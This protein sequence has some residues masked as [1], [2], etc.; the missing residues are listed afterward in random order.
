MARFG[1]RLFVATYFIRRQK[2]LTHGRQPNKG[3][4]TRSVFFH[5]SLDDR[6]LFAKRLAILL[7]AG[8]PILEGLRMLQKQIRGRSAQYVLMEIA[9]GIEEGLSLHSCLEKFHNFFGDFFINVVR[10]GESTGTLHQSLEYL[11]EELRKQR[12]MKKKII[13]ALVY[14]C[15]IVVATIGITVLLITSVFPKI[16]PVLQ[17]FKGELPFT[18][19]T[20]IW[21]SH[22]FLTEGWLILSVLLIVIISFIVLV[23]K[24]KKFRLLVDTVSLKLPLVGKL[25]KYYQIANFC[26][27][28]GILL[29]SDAGIMEAIGI[30]THTTSNLAFQGVLRELSKSLMRGEKISTFLEKKTNLFP[31]MVWQMVTVGEITGSL[32]SCFIYLAEIYE[33]EMDEITKNLSTAIEP[34][35]MIFMGVLVGFIAMSIITPIY[36]LTQS[37]SR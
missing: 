10:V 9:K 3:S 28:L 31:P 26:R 23:R 13:S 24:S 7:N 27:T 21:V 30:T 22:L 1:N 11:A 6:I 19:R 4:K 36:S 17:T 5:L 12:D 2:T 15:L 20:L 34:M 14:P 8:V 29:K 37:L 32:S 25:F 18:T 16:L 33:K 35:L